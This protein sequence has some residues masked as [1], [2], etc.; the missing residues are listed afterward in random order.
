MKEQMKE[1]LVERNQLL[2]R[3]EGTPRVYAKDSE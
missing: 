2:P 3:E 1:A